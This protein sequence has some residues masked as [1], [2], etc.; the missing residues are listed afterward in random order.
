MALKRGRLDHMAQHVAPSA[1]P[2]A[3]GGP[4]WDV[5]LH[6]GRV[7]DPASG[8]DSVTN[9][10]IA[11]DRIA[12]VGDD[13]DPA[14]A[15]VARDCTGLVVCPGFIDLHA[16]GQNNESCAPTPRPTPPRRRQRSPR[17][18]AGGAGGQK[19]HPARPQ[20]AA[21][22]VRRRDDAARARARHLARRHLPGPA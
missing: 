11:G 4:R 18:A 12:A 2:T 19:F 22:G 7:V 14:D 13:V 10:A 16:H 8:L 15:A 17:V 3:G 1:A 21:A 20:G 5:V 6:G 9:L